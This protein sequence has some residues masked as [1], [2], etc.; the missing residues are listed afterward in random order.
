MSDGETITLLDAG[1]TQ[2]KVRIAG[3]DAP[4]KGQAFGERSK[5]SLSVLVSNRRSLRCAQVLG[6]SLSHFDLPV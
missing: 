5:Q 1:K 3:I 2:H 6:E 4:E